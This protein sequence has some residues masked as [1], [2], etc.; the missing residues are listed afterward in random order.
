MECCHVAQAGLELLGSRYPPTSASQKV[1]FAEASSGDTTGWHMESRS[2]T[3]LECSGVISAHCNLHPPGSSDSPASASR[4]AGITESGFPHVG[5]AGLELLTS[6]D[7]PTSASRSAGIT[8]VSHC[9]WLPV[10]FYSRLGTASY[11]VTQAGMQWRNLGSWVH[12]NL[13]LLG[14][15][16]CCASVSRVAGITGKH[17]HTRLIFFFFFEMESRSVARLER[18]GEI[19]AHCNLRLLSLPKMGFR[20]VGQAGLKLLSS[21]VPPALAS[22]S[23]GITE[24]RSVFQAGVQWHDLGSLQPLPSGFKQFCCLS[25][26]SS[27]DYRHVPPR[28]ANFCILVETGFHHIGQAGLELLTSGDPPASASQTSGITGMSY[29]AQPREFF[30]CILHIGPL[31]DMSLKL[32]NYLNPGGGGCGEQM[33]RQVWPAAAV[34]AGL[35]ELRSSVAYAFGKVLP[36]WSLALWPGLQCSGAVSAHCNLC[37]LGSSDSPDSASQVAG[38]IGAHYHAQLIF[39]VFLNRDGVSLCWPGWSQT[40]DL[41]IHLPRPPRVLGLQA[42]VKAPGLSLTSK[43]EQLLEEFSSSLGSR[44]AICSPNAAVP[45]CYQEWEKLFWGPVFFL[46]VEIHDFMFQ[47]YSA[48]GFL[49]MLLFPLLSQA[50]QEPQDEVKLFIHTLWSQPRSLA[51]SNYNWDYRHIPLCLANFEKFVV[52]TSFRHIA[53]AGLKLLGSSSQS[54]SAFQSAGITGVIHYMESS[55]SPGLEGSGAISAHCNLRLLGSSNSHASASPVVWT[56][57]MRHHAWLIFVFLVELGFRHVGQAG[58]ELLTSSDPATSTSQSAGILGSLPVTQAGARWCNLSSL[59]PL[60][61]GFKQ[62]SCL[63]LLRTGFHYVGQSDL[64]LLTSSDLLA[65]TPPLHLGGRILLRESGSVAQAG[66]TWCTWLTAASAFEVQVI[67]L[68][69]PSEQL[70]LQE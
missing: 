43:H 66:Y 64:K 3:Q 4:I 11:S 2:V 61:P 53:Q 57:G 33:H 35:M 31:S 28:R 37:L 30:I 8:A 9:A 6:G 67:L 46:C 32:E 68:P 47:Y 18:S 56:T 62:F 65:W 10:R 23:A 36:W 14:S 34:F 41:V 58:L 12:H 40:P 51:E 29:R 48:R 50:G 70:R 16:G 7:P 25:L 38:I 59:Q 24:C 63:S 69:Q 15:N 5:Q 52:E 19:S 42:G 20:C 21:S 44:A 54:T 26:P 22:Q 49:L 45:A 60:P 39:C 55:P 17:R 1:I 13:R 27:W